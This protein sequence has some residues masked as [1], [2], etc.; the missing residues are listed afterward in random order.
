[1]SIKIIN[2]SHTY[3]FNT[4][5][6]KTALFNVNLQIDEGEFAAIAGH[7]GS[8][9]ST[10]I[11]VMAGLIKPT[12]GN[13]LIDD[14]DLNSKNSAKIRRRVGIV[15]QYPENQLFAETVEKDI[16][17]APTNFNL[18]TSEINK[19]IHDSMSMVNLSYADFKDVSPFNLSGGQK[20]RVA[21]AGV[22]AM[23]PKYL[24][25]DEPT[26][27]LDPRSRDDLM[28]QI[29]YLHDKEKL[30][31]IL[32]SHNMD[33]ISQFAKRLIILNQGQVLADDSPKNLFKR[34]DVLDTAGLSLPSIT[35]LML[36]LKASGLN[37]N[38]NVIDIESAEKLF[39]K[40]SL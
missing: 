24:I 18:D 8:G 22:L 23:N 16:A 4:P 25:L 37:V 26:V 17:F 35:K 2:V 34:Q 28:K 30:T 3:A 33:I 9:K 39:D 40:K 29:K 19:R 31:V 13:I 32:V 12:A 38:T 7:T 14:V 21:I 15:F 5:F 1:M 27:G 10:L 36:T 20:R 11:Q 6:E